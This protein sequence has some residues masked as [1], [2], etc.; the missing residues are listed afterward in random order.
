M[1]KL[2][3]ICLAAFAFLFSN[4]TFAQETEATN[5]D[6]GFRLG[7]GVNGGLPTDGDY[8]WALGGD[9]RLQ[10]DL[11][12]KTSL[13]LTTGFTNLFNGDKDAAGNDIKDLGFIPAKAGF[14]A[15]V[16]KDQFYVLGE[17][18][19]GFAVT[20]GYNN[21]TF[22]WAPGI[23]YANKYIDLSVRYEDYHDFRTNQVAL[24]VAYG[25]KL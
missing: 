16:L 5:Y 12:K 11:S 14:K 15:F 22:L 7:F 2:Q 21:T 23:G 19:A 13:T 4:T 8:D 3:I 24:R 9:V 25:F 6:Q 20:N 17:V 10:Y 1:K 18:G